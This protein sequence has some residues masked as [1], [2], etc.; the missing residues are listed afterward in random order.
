MHGF[1]L[2][3][4]SSRYQQLKDA[5]HRAHELLKEGVAVLAYLTNS[6]PYTTPQAVLV[7]LNHPGLLLWGL[8]PE[9]ARCN[10]VG[11]HSAQ[12]AAAHDCIVGR[13]IPP[14]ADTCQA[15]R[16][17]ALRCGALRVSV[18]LRYALYR[19]ERFS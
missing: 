1:A 5:L 11:E 19:T 17:I 4:N 12:G 9:P 10:G 7:S 16:V 3:Q 15:E 6:Q 8:R 14:F 2:P 13:F 18:N